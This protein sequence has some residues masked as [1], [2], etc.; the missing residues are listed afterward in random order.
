MSVRSDY[1]PEAA[2]VS[3]LERSRIDKPKIMTDI[4]E[5]LEAEAQ[6]LTEASNRLELACLNFGFISSTTDAHKEE[7]ET[8]KMVIP[9][10][11]N[12]FDRLDAS[13]RRIARAKDLIN[14]LIQQIERQLS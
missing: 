13:N 1:P 11:A 14:Q 6:G 10:P 2:S 7:V 12:F 4:L 3:G 8:D 9:P 5:E